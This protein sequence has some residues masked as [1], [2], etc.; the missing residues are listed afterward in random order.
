MKEIDFN[1]VTKFQKAV[2]ESLLQIPKG[3]VTCYKKIAEKIAC[4]SCQAVGQA[5]KKNPFAPDVP[6]HRVIKSDLTVGGFFGEADGDKVKKKLN[7]LSI[8][9]VE[10]DSQGS[11]KDK[12]KLFEFKSD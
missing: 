11:L 9:G 12:S 3:R 2:Y 1:S 4:N 5:L 10:F 8:E 7:L 6:C